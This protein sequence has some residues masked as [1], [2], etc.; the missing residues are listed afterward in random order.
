MSLTGVHPLWDVILSQNLQA[1]TDQG[2]H[3]ERSSHYKGTAY[4]GY[5]V[6][7]YHPDWSQKPFG[8][9]LVCLP[10]DP[11]GG[12][13]SK[14]QASNSLVGIDLEPEPDGACCLGHLERSLEKD[15][16]MEGS[17]HGRSRLMDQI[18]RKG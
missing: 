16:R 1:V 6:A 10:L 2:C 11:A 13:S 5:T 17:G 8:N 12:C 4:R 18:G 14:V 9:S 7:H 15:S 3:L